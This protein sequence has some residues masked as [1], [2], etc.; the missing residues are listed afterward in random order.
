M[1]RAYVCTVPVSGAATACF[2]CYVIAMHSN[3]SCPQ[4]VTTTV[5]FAQTHTGKIL[6]VRASAFFTFHNTQR[7]SI[8]FSTRSPQRQNVIKMGLQQNRTGGGGGSFTGLV[9]LRIGTDGGPL[10]L[11]KH[12]FGWFKTRGTFRLS[13]EPESTPFSQ[14]ASYTAGVC[15]EL[16]RP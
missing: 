16:S 2:C 12:T 7:I 6:C 13:D 14:S 5:C 15:K 1:H 11:R 8:K 9:F 3:V 10:R 4:F